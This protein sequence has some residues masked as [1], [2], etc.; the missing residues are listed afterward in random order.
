MNKK[1]SLL[2]VGCALLASCSNIE[3]PI[4]D[5]EFKE[6]TEAHNDGIGT[7]SEGKRFNN[8]LA[9]DPVTLIAPKL[10]YQYKYSDKDSDGNNDH[11][12]IRYVAAINSTAVT[13][14]WTRTIYSKNGTVYKAEAEKESTKYYTSVINPNKGGASQAA[15]D[16][17][18]DDST[19]PYVGF[20]VYSLLDIPLANY[21]DYSLK[22]SLTITDTADKT[23]TAT[24]GNGIVYFGLYHDYKMIG[25]FGTGNYEYETGIETDKRSDFNNFQKGTVALEAGDEFIF[26]DY[27][28]ATDYGYSHVN[29]ASKG[30]FK[31]GSVENSIKV[32]AD[33]NYR[34]YVKD[35]VITAYASL[36]Y[37]L[38]NFGDG[39]FAWNIEDNAIKTDPDVGDNNAQFSN[40]KLTTGD[41]WQIVNFYNSNDTDYGTQYV[42]WDYKENVARYFYQAAADSQDIVSVYTDTYTVYLNSSYRIYVAPATTTHTVYFTNPDS[43]PEGTFYAYPYNSDSDKQAAWPGVE[44]TKVNGM[45]Q[46]D[47]NFN[48]QKIIFNNGNGNGKQTGNLDF[49]KNKYTGTW[50]WKL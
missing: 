5:T 21:L 18:A 39:S 50:E 1:F 42:G 30:L 24:S 48:Y 7:L 33:G 4:E 22:V 3:V 25:T 19:K 12:S 41:K 29:A 26:R 44:M 15:K 36:G 20:V 2:L 8:A 43:W 9:E 16:V 10:G 14:V 32:L 34:F 45:W 17:E 11:I 35:G 23:N 49:E 28:T 40:V 13:A 38:V 27:D 6:S 31:E 37:Y 46:A 47:V